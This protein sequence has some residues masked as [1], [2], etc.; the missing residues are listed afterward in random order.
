MRPPRPPR[1]PERGN[2][3]LLALIVM[4][5]LATLGSLT[6]V[7]MQSS[8]QMSTNDRAQTI[9]MYAAESG[10]AVAMDFLRKHFDASG[11]TSPFGAA[12]SWSAYCTPNNE[13]PLFD[14]ST[15]I[16]SS[17]AKPGSTDAN[18]PN[19]FDPKLNAWFHIDIL[20]NRDDQAYTNT[21]C[22]NDGILI[23][24]STGHGPQGSLAIIEWTVQRVGFWGSVQ[25]TA[26]VVPPPAPVPPTRPPVA[27]NYWL[28]P[29]TFVG[30]GSPPYPPS[31]TGT[32][33]WNSWLPTSLDIH[34]VGPPSFGNVGVVLLGWRI[35]SL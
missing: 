35:V 17:D 5:A 26:N 31:L 34:G 15:V 28:F 19:L 30:G 8:I 27:P 24:R 4:S 23:I 14:M 12:T 20:N 1:D 11:P 10:A 18:H 9:A 6:V 25:D 13:L 16:G 32:D 2:S 33:G 21:N 29:P 3:L 7:S 22:D